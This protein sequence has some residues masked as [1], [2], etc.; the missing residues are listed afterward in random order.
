M[1]KTKDDATAAVASIG[2]AAECGK[3]ADALVRRVLGRVMRQ[4][5]SVATALDYVLALSRDVRANAW[6]V[7]EKAGHEGPYRMQALLGR[8]KWAGRTCGNSSR[9][10]PRAACRTTR[11]T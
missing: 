8:Y 9:R 10:W 1:T 2:D 4:A 6:E 3:R 11:V 5:R 7:A